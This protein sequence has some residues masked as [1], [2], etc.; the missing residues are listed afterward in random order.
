M[1]FVDL[2]DHFGITQLAIEDEKNLELMRKVTTESTVSITGKV[3]ERSNKN[4]NLPT[5]DIEVIP[6][7]IRVTGKSKN[8]L[9]FEINIDQDVRE[10]LSID[11]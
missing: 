11:F 9:P 2:R 10:D 7:E 3:A 4:P 1:M 5:G 8:V 6:S